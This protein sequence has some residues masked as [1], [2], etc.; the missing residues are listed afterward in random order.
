[1]KVYVLVAA[2]GMDP[3]ETTVIGAYASAE[4]AEAVRERIHADTTAYWL[5]LTTAQRDASDR[6]KQWL[7]DAQRPQPWPVGWIA[8]LGSLRVLAESWEY[9]Q[10]AMLSEDERQHLLTLAVTV[11][12]SEAPPDIPRFDMPRPKFSFDN[13]Q[14]AVAETELEEAIL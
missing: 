11:F 6:W 4:L 2:H 14:M 13:Y 12:P 7:K 3:P 1:M 9:M 8:Q 10:R 5:A